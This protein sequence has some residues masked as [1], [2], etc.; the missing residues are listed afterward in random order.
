LH[1]QCVCSET[2]QAGFSETLTIVKFD[3]MIAGLTIK[4][5]GLVALAR[6]KRF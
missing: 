6:R 1:L 3:L 5:G 4:V 2:R